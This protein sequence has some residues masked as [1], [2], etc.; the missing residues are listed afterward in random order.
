MSTAILE[1]HSYECSIYRKVSLEGNEE[2]EA[3]EEELII[4]NDHIEKLVKDSSTS[5]LSEYHHFFQLI[6]LENPEE[7]DLDFIDEYENN[8]I[9]LEPSCREF[10]DFITEP[11][12]N[13]GEGE[14][15]I[16]FHLLPITQKLV[17][18]KRM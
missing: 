3:F 2:F 8:E 11:Y 17:D 7:D 5:L 10:V 9:T 1:L 15:A 18:E 13:S 4:Y 14:F 6:N 12:D 16:G